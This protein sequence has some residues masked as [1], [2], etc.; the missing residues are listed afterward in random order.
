MDINPLNVPKAR[1]IE[2]F[3]GILAQKVYEGGWEAK[4][5]EQLKDRITSCLNKFNLNDLQTLMSG[6]KGKLRSIADK[7]VL[8]VYKK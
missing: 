1:S 7:G 2:D 3:W 4:N 6:I 5:E 8:S